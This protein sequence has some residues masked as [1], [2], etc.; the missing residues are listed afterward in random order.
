MRDLINRRAMHMTRLIDELL[1]ASRISRGQVFLRVEHLDLTELVRRTT[2]DHRSMIEQR[3]LILSLELP[4]RPL[5][6]NADAVRMAQVLGNLLHNSS[7]FVDPGGMVSVSLAPTEDGCGARITVH[8]NGVGIE[9][10]SLA[11]IFQG[12]E[13]GAVSRPKAHGL[14]LG[15]SVVQ[16]LVRLHGGTVTAASAG[17]GLGSTFTVVLPLAHESTIGPAQPVLS[18]RKPRICKVLIVDDSPEITRSLSLLLRLSG[19]HVEVAEDGKSGIEL[20]RRFLPDV[21]LCD[22]RMPGELDGYMVAQRLRSAPTAQKMYLVALT[23]FGQDRDRQRACEAGFDRHL[24]KPVLESS[25]DE[26]LVELVGESGGDT[27]TSTSASKRTA[28]SSATT[29]A[30][31]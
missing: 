3:G 1:D 28:A 30:S 7:K 25:L 14:G 17:S 22:I 19:H 20:A 4:D 13:A 8:D 2:E 11:T 18:R 6:V 5:G 27:N 29:S 23:G 26:L 10:D 21:V 24:T 9:P 16:G 31:V 12:L 15:L